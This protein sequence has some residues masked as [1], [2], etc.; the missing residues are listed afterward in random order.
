MRRVRG[1]AARAHEKNRGE[2]TIGIEIGIA[3]EIDRD[4]DSDLDSEGK[5]DQPS[6]GS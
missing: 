2:Q 1:L 5:V 3:I 6:S 4:F